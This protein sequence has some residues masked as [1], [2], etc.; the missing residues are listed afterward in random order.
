ML[1]INNI[2]KNLIEKHLNGFHYTTQKNIFDIIILYLEINN[3]IDIESPESIFV[4]I[5]LDI[6]EHF[7]I[8]FNDNDLAYINDINDIYK[9]IVEKIK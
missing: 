1:N 5:L 8:E 3:L 7:D 2:L 9:I 4:N 6:E